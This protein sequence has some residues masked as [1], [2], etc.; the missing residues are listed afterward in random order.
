MRRVLLRGLWARK[1]R[2]VATVAAVALG[3]AFL[4]GTLVLG[5]TM[6]AGFDERV[7]RGQRRHRRRGARPRR[8]LH[9]GRRRARPGADRRG[10]PARARS[11]ASSP[12]SPWS[13]AR[14][15]SWPPT[16]IRSAG[17]DRRRWPAAGSPT[18]HLNPY[19]LAEGRAPA[20]RGRGGGQPRCRRAGRPGRRRRRRGADARPRSGHDR[21]DRHVR[22][23]RRHRADHLR[24]LL[25]RRGQPAAPAPAGRGDQRARG[26]GRT[27][28]ARR[29][30]SA[31]SRRRCSTTASRCSPARRSPPSRTPTSN[32]DFI[33]FF[34]TLLLVF[35]GISLV[36]ATFSIYNT[37]AI[38]I[39]QRT[40]ESA[41][42]RALGA[43]RRQIAVGVA[44]EAVVLGLV[45]GVLGAAAGAGLAAGLWR[46]AGDGPRHRAA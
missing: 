24:R 45:G 9:R 30:W 4:G 39:A 2:L 18:P 13:R 44:V 11:T 28:C 40:R 1:R 19:V 8:P 7:H 27:G 35:A 32:E 29:S 31:G 20:G 37:F 43:S 46:L 22:R 42:L 33:G 36:V 26:G 5:D 3:V 21:R 23:G 15:S 25:L 16:A 10:R 14:A 34:E 12:S 6:R 41:L 38:T 17:T